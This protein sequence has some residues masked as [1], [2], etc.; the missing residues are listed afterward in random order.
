MVTIVNNLIFLL[1]TGGF[2]LG[3]AHCLLGRIVSEAISRHIF[4]NASRDAADRSPDIVVQ[5]SQ[6]YDQLDVPATGKHHRRRLA[7]FPAICVRYQCQRALVRLPHFQPHYGIVWH[8]RQAMV[9][10]VPCS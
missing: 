1:N 4:P 6:R 2:V 9:A 10:R 8:A 5:H 7:T 3:C